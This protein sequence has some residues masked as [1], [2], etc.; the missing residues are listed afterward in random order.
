VHARWWVPRTTQASA[1]RG[2]FNTVN[3][4]DIEL[5]GLDATVQ[6]AMANWIGGATQYNAAAGSIQ[7]DI[8]TMNMTL[9]SLSSEIDSEID[10]GAQHLHQ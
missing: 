4:I 7:R 10:T 8:D 2:S 5:H 6:R 3:K 9:R 1:V